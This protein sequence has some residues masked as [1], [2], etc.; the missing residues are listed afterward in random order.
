MSLTQP[1]LALAGIAAVHV[2]AHRLRFLDGT[3]R[4][5]WLSLAGGISLAYVFLHFMPELAHGQDLLAEE[6]AGLSWVEYELFG[7]ALV[8]L[9]AYY[10]LERWVQ[11][12]EA[13]RGRDPDEGHGVF[14]VHLASFAIYNAI[15]GYLLVHRGGEEGHGGGLWPF[16]VAMALHFLVT[17]Y[18]L[19]EGFAD[20]WRRVGRWVLVAALGL[21]FALGAAV[22]LPELAILTAIA[23]LGGGMVLNVLKEELPEERRSR[24][25][26]LV[27]GAAGYAGLLAA[28]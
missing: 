9:L 28:A 2:A 10:G 27:L 6:G 13:R 20:A 22:A 8:G 12:A 25:W 5:V 26:A 18:G 16:A 14:W 7:A 15:T 1:L 3:P 17:D 11:E 24:F 21:G 23:L 19:R 4:S